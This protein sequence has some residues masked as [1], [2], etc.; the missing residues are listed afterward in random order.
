MTRNKLNKGDRR[1]SIDKNPEYHQ[2]YNRLMTKS[3]ILNAEARRKDPENAGVFSNRKTTELALVRLV[4]TEPDGTY[5][6]NNEEQTGY[7]VIAENAL[8]DIHRRFA[9]WQKDQVARG[10]SYVL[11]EEWPKA[12]FDEKLRLEAGVDIRH[13]ER[14]VL[15]R[16]IEKLKKQDSEK[17]SKKVLRY[18]PRRLGFNP[19]GVKPEI[20]DQKVS[21]SRGD[22]PIPFID[23][24]SSPYNRMPVREFRKLA[25]DYKK[26]QDEERNKLQAQYDD[27]IRKY[28]SSDISVPG[29]GTQKNFPKS[30]LPAWPDGVPTI[31][32]VEDELKK[33]TAE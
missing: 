16:E 3:P 15:E 1:Y 25:K 9:K 10:N 23:E 31:E 2:V 26:K 22:V 7:I 21:F 29:Y 12:L 18:F 17:R 32:Q 4:G 27:E 30:K 13:R 20:C 33:Q 8:A 28:G 5:L 19:Q 24:P 14:K 11:P 6:L